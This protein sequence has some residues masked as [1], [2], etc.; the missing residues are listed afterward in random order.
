MQENKNHKAKFP[1]VATLVAFVA[2]VIMLA[3]GFWQLER[4][5][6]KEVRL[7]QI[8][9]AST[10]SNIQLNQVLKNYAS[11]QDF[12][13]EA[14]GN[15]LT[16]SFYI[17]NK[18]YDGRAG[19]HVYQPFQTDYG[20]LMLDLGWLPSDAPRPA[21][22]SY[23]MLNFSNVTGALYIPQN[24]RLINETNRH[25]GRFPA[26][27][28]QVDLSEMEQH[29]NA[30]LLPFVLRIQEE[31]NSPFVRDWQAVIMSPQKHLAYAIQWFG[32]AIAGLTVYLLSALKRM[33]APHPKNKNGS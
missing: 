29:L 1:V 7:T 15:L 31:D 5:N 20:M 12:I 6:Q 21:L 32:L 4:K 25:Y 33:H 27:L 3:L 22:P 9:F 13:I 23:K 10:Q 11:Y 17:D 19:F 30:P 28:Q 26:L 2:I 18:L 8:E 16:Q 24:N 14:E